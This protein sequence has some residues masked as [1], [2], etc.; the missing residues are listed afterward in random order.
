VAV[1]ARKIQAECPTLLLDESDAAFR[2]PQDYSEGLRSILN[3]GYRHGGCT[4]LCVGKGAQI[5]YKDFST[6]CAKAI[7][8]IGQLPDTVADRSI[9][10]RLK[11]RTRSEQIERFRFRDAEKQALVLRRELK[12]WAER[13][14]SKLGKARPSL[15]EE[16]SDRQQDVAEP[17]LAIAEAVGGEWPERARQA[18]V[19]LCTGRAAQ[20]QS[21]GVQLL[22]DIRAIFTERGSDK[23]ASTDLVGALVAREGRPWAES[24]RG[25]TLTPNK[26]ARLLAPYDISPANVRRSEQQYKGY[27][28]EWFEDAFARYLPIRIEAPEPSQPSQGNVYAAKEQVVEAFQGV[29]GTDGK[30]GESPDAARV[31]TGGTLSPRST[32][33]EEVPSLAEFAE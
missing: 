25:K 32:G 33:T 11:R 4:S 6:F 13:C 10:I 28:L 29:S 9:P 31:G 14:A 22:D 8:G 21:L 27:R 24:E 15:P 3:M 5:R 19:E 23:I 1:L 16:L 30:G 20:D 17:L 12:P 18:L 26:L 2:G 7:A